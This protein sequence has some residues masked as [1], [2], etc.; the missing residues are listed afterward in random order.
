MAI[1]TV[2]IFSER[3]ELP[4]RPCWRFRGLGNAFRITLRYIESNA[5]KVVTRL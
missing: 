5:P 3:L 2:L 4:W 1:M